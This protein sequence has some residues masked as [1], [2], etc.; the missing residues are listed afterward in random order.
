M[1][2][3]KPVRKPRKK[4]PAS[5]KIYLYCPRVVIVRRGE[6]DYDAVVSLMDLP[7]YMRELFTEWA[8]LEDRPAYSEY[9]AY[10]NDFY[11]WF[12]AHSKDSVNA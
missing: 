9:Y 5:P 1:K 11:D 3:N 6:D 2:K 10:H 4:P 8:A 7:K 12:Q